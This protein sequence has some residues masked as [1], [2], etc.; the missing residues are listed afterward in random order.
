MAA[1]LLRPTPTNRAKDALAGLL[2]SRP[3]LT[4]S[5]EAGMLRP[6]V[7]PLVKAVTLHK[8]DMARTTKGA[9]EGWLSD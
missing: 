9:S 6:A 3:A 2:R 4:P 5:K 7:H 1:H 8:A